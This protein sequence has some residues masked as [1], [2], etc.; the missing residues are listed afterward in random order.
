MKIMRHL[1]AIGAVFVCTY[2]FAFAQAYPIKTVRVVIPWPP[3]GSN[4][5]VGRLLMQKLTEM[6]GQQFVIDNRGGA[7]GTIGSDLVAKS[8]PDGYTIMVHSAT[9][10][11]NPHLYGKLPYDT[12]RDFTSIAPLSAQIG[13]LV[14]HP[15]LPVKSVKEF[16]S[17]AKV[18]PGEIV[19]ASSGNGSFVHLT[20]A[21]FNVMSGTKM[22][23]IPYKGGGPAAIAIASGETQAMI[24][25]IG[26]VMQQI[27]SKRVRPLAVTSDYRVQAFPDVPTIAESG[28]PG[29]EF[30]AWIGAFGPAGMPKPI[31]DKLN[32]DIQKVLKM[33]DVGDKLKAQTLDP[34]FMT[35]EQFAKRVKS[36]YD[37][38]EKVI[39]ISGAKVD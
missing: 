17:L 21:L 10:V 26:S 15:S 27:H 25:T 3:G 12:L 39:K 36:D 35:P 28:V 31:V 37:K 32:A 4:D 19:Y 1:A 13:M 16:I 11:A 29:Y 30:T 8:A 34:I 2:G 18:R 23:H 7:A 5:I 33:P 20:M 14:V 22:V 9:H 24:A 6:A 38:Y